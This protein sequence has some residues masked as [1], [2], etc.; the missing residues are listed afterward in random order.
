VIAR[1]REVET[2]ERLLRRNVVV[3]ILGA[4]Q[5][6]KSTLAREVAD[7]RRGP[8]MYFDL[9]NDEDVARLSDPLLALKALRGLVI[10][11]EI[12]H[13]PELFRTLRVLADRRDRPC[14]FLVLGS[15]SPDLLKQS[16]ETLAGRIAYHELGGFSLDEVG[17]RR[18]ERLWC[19]GGFPRSFL[20]RTDA[21][22]MAWR[23]EFVRTFVERDVPGLGIRIAPP[24]LRRFWTMLAHYHGNVWNS[25]EFARSFGVA[26]TTVRNY[27]DLLSS[28]LVIR[29][30]Q[31][32]HA[33]VAKRQ[34]KAPKVY[35]VDSG[36]LHALLNLPRQVDVEGH[37][38]VG[39]S[40]EGFAIGEIAKHLEAR[41]DECF[42]WATH[43]GAELD[44]LV[45]RGGSRRGFEIKH[46]SSPVVTPSM[47][48]ALADLKLD[49]LDVVHAGDRTFDLAPRIRA[50]ALS[51][52]LL[53]VPSL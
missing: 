1:V 45:A 51:R 25:S 33:N 14:R 34:V 28:V 53:D 29:Q 7:R 49:S 41:F 50:V 21:D 20:A 36:L 27:L 47:R 37:P 44:L 31:P 9:E 43:S 5:V 48:S 38:K 39:A 52:L 46:T 10:I 2:L 4:R 24:T 13:R 3:G 11:D 16:S 26:D 32:W 6:G 18:A 15:A 17:T 23:R 35:L 40:W 19:R 8:V 22:S 12:Q 42:F 30:L